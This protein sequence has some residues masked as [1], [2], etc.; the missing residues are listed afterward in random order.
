MVKLHHLP[1]DQPISLRPEARRSLYCVCVANQLVKFCHV[2]CEDMEIDI[3]PEQVM[4]ELGLPVETEKLL[5]KSM[6]G[7]IQKAAL[8]GAPGDNTPQPRSAAA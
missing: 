8:L 2:Y 1:K 4:I 6:Q 5:D 3:I 7:I